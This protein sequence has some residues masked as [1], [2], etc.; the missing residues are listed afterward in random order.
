MERKH[1][2]TV[3]AFTV[4]LCL[5]LYLKVSW[6]KWTVWDTKADIQRLEERIERLEQRQR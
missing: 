4:F 1:V 2:L 5:V 3:L 6:E